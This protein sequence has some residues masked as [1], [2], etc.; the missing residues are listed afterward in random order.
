MGGVTGLRVLGS[1]DRREE[2]RGRAGDGRGNG[3]R[4]GGRGREMQVGTGKERRQEGGC[5][6]RVQ[7]VSA[8][9]GRRLCQAVGGVAAFGWHINFAE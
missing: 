1:R 9:G 2:G 5:F 6:S 4:E 8:C 3:E 7:G